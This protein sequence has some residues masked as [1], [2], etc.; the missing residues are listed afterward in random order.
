MCVR[1]SPNFFFHAEDGIRDRTVTGVQTC[2][3]PISGSSW[4]TP[5]T[6]P[7]RTSTA[8]TGARPRQR[9]RPPPKVVTDGRRRRSPRASGPAR[10][11]RPLHRDDG[12][13]PLP[14]LRG[15]VLRNS[16]RGL[17]L[18]ARIALDV[19]AGLSIRDERGELPRGHSRKH[20]HPLL[21]RRHGP[22]RS[23]VPPVSGTA[24]H[25]GHSPCALRRRHRRIDLG[26]AGGGALRGAPGR[27]RAGRA[28]D[29]PSDDAGREGCDAV[30]AL[31]RCGVVLPVR[32]A[33]R[34]YCP[35]AVKT[36]LVSVVVVALLAG[37][38]G[39]TQIVGTKVTL[40]EY[41]FDPKDLSVQSGKVTFTLV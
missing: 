30:L 35:T 13:V 19:A 23:G 32:R 27:D 37:C 7:S 38:G 31:R 4:R 40:S 33:I 28:V 41:K 3:L 39:G 24:P 14:R 17:L 22:Y 34:R 25:R 5:A 12:H 20:L 1:A 10:T 9:C 21:E 16:L 29:R 15:D 11:A 18:P 8:T 36:L 26:G 6:S 2:A